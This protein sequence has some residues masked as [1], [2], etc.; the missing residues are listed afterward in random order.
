MTTDF[1]KTEPVIS[2]GVFLALVFD[3]NGFES[4]HGT[5]YRVHKLQHDVMY[6]GRDQ[7]PNDEICALDLFNV[8]QAY[9]QLSDFSA[10]E[11]KRL[12]PELPAAAQGLLLHLG[13]IE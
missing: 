3:V 4:R 13:M 12:V 7:V 11:I 10:L 9:Q 6:L 5:R 1:R 2:L 8:Y